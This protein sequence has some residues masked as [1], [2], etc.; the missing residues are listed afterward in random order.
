MVASG[1]VVLLLV[2]VPSL[3]FLVAGVVLLVYGIRRQRQA[4]EALQAYVGQRL[5]E[6]E[7]PAAERPGM[8]PG[9]E[10]TVID[11]PEG[12]LPEDEP[13]TPAV[14]PPPQDNTGL[15]WAIVGGVLTF[16]GITGLCF[17][18]V[19]GAIVTVRSQT[20]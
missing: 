8:T 14:A 4:R 7:R 9:A 11:R 19:V 12:D 18:L 1:I 3:L 6:G 13:A 5:Q 10:Q 16:F 15:V 17:V 20:G 2:L